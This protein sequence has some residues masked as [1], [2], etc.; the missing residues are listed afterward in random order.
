LEC[1]SGTS[2]T[3]LGKPSEAFFKGAVESLGCSA[4]EVVMVGDD[5]LADVEGA[6]LAGLQ[7]ILVQTGKYRSGD[8]AQIKRPGAVVLAD[9]AEAIEWILANR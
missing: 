2:A 4:S 8:E 5:A 9:V 3:V 6:L 7:G 1:A